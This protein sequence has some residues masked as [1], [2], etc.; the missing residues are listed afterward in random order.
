MRG[1][2]CLLWGF[3]RQC[4]LALPGD[5]LAGVA[6]TTEKRLVMTSEGIS[7]SRRL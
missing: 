6:V 2:D 1:R 7:I 3:P 4:H 5:F